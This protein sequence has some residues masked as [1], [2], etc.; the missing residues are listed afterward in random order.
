[1]FDPPQH[2][3]LPR[4]DGRRKAEYINWMLAEVDTYTGFIIPQ[5][6]TANRL[7]TWENL[8][9]NVVTLYFLQQLEYPCPHLV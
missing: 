5:K 7:A 6:T 9:P 3:V 2:P 4:P 8:A 1:M